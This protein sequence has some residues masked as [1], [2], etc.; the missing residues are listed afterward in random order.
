MYTLIQILLFTY[1]NFL[2]T[3]CVIQ[4]LCTIQLFTVLYN[5]SSMLFC[6][7][8]YGVQYHI[9]LYC[10]IPYDTTQYYMLP[11]IVFFTASYSIILYY[12][13]SY[14]TVSHCTVPHCA[15]LYS[16]VLYRKVF[17]NITLYK[18]IDF[19]ILFKQE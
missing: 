6:T 9:V 16:H 18:K 19:I 5:Y 12:I 13:V 17:Q 8:S 15:I 10:K 2:Q 1:F 4:I 14:C 7:V 11:Y 3:L